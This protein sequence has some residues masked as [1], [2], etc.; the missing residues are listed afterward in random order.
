MSIEREILYYLFTEKESFK[1]ILDKNVSP[2]LFIEESPRD[3]NRNKLLYNLSLD[4][5]RN[6]GETLSREAL[7]RLLE[8]S[9]I[10]SEVVV[11]LLEAYDEILLLAKPKNSL[12]FLI[13]SLRSLYKKNKLRDMLVNAS[14]MFSDNNISDIIPFA[15][16]TIHDISQ[17]TDES[18]SEGSLADVADER[19]VDYLETPTTED[20]IFSGFKTLDKVTNGFYPGQLIIIAAATNEGKSV[21]LLNLAY[22]A[23]KY[24]NKN[25]LYITIENYR[26][27]LLRRFDSLDANI[28]YN[29]LK[30]KNLSDDEKI[31][32]QQ[33]LKE[34]KERKNIFYV[35]DRPAEC[36]P[37]F[38][39]SKI[40][41]LRPLTFDLLVVD[42]LHIMQLGINKKLERD[43]I[44]GNIAAELR[45]I[46]RI[47]KMPVLTAVQINREGIKEKGNNYGLQHI[48]LSQFISNHADIILSLRTIDQTQAL[49]SG[50]VD[51]DAILIKHRDG[52][53]AHFN[54]KA[55]FER[56]KMQELEIKCEETVP[57]LENNNGPEEDL[58]L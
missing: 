35:V 55:N 8:V 22:N 19:I 20:G 10:K 23:W 1:T 4:Y 44:Y 41:D 42:Y 52:P 31:R 21:M 11:D 56:M 2:Y 39:E 34:Q 33:S 25:V 57:V 7:R 28:P 37:S 6:Y 16:N 53:K 14:R 58:E 48:A 30:N 12:V 18:G 26:N 38:I 46:G 17:M 13:D 49:A 50:I 45:R 47:K 3:I 40:N 24:Y 54:I 5:Y 36:T 32:L 27:D 29:K 9:N 51:L 43:Q 15:Q